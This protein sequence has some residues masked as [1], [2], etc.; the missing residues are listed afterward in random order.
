MATTIVTKSG[1]GA[2]TASDLVA[3]EL[4][5]DLTNKRLYTEDS[6]GTVLELGTNPSG[7]VTFGDSGKAIFGADSDLQIYHDGSNSYIKDAGTG[8]LRIWADSPNIATASGNKIFYGNAGSAELYTSG[9]ALRLSTTATGINVTGSVTADGL[10]VDGLAT[11]SGTGP[12]LQLSETDT[13]DK[14]TYLNTGGGTFNIQT[15]DDAGT[16]YTKRLSM[17]NA[18]GDI[19]FYEDT[20]TTPKLFWDASSEYLGIGT[21]TPTHA[22]N[23]VVSDNSGVQIESAAGHK[24]YLFFGDEASNTV[25][26]VGYDHATD[27][28]GLWTASAEV[29]VI[30]SSGIAV[31]G[32]VTT[33]GNVGIGTDSPAASLEVEESG[34]GSGLGG[35]T[36]ST[37]TAGGN[38]GYRF[39]T[40]GVNR[41]SLSIVGSAGSESLRVY[42]SNN[43]AERMR[44]DSSGNVIVGGTT[45][46]AADAV[47]LLPDGEVTA[48]GFYFS[49]NIGAAMNDT[50]IRKATTSTMV[51]DTAS[52]E[53]MRIDASGHAIIP[54][55]V[56]LGTATGV[57]A[58]ANTLD[59]YEEGTWTPAPARLTGGS[60]TTDGT[61]T[62]TGSY[63]KVGRQVT[64]VCNIAITGT[65]TQ[66]TSNTSITGIPFLPITSPRF[67]PSAIG[68]QSALTNN[69]NDLWGII[70]D[71]AYNA[72]QTQDANPWVAGSLQLTCTY[73]TA[74]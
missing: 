57:Y 43:S 52:T 72:L 58:A 32:S 68:S 55:G 33:T 31:T 54:A 59:D 74:S 2:P 17:S 63:T 62:A 40:G 22:L 3:G 30:D 71:Y 1:S 37:T 41:F 38:A 9:G 65:I 25:G 23:V 60:I 29:V 10:T 44:I 56:T 49:N 14:N 66:G 21:S 53:R 67:L 11:I 12:A 35:V 61:I 28:M 13:T 4:A 20:G 18:T 27:A 6:G 50:G 8:D 48:A 24:A 51:F 34:T 73:F 45:A 70:A 7:N 36:A 19:S 69:V 5:V 42:D 16:G 39:A 47:T 15:V 46:Q 64:I 26:R